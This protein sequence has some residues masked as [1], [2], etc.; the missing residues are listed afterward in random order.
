MEI[1]IELSI[2]LTI[3]V[4]ISVLMRLL[5][6]PLIIG[7]ILAGILVSPYFLNIVQS[8]QT[9][10]V[11]SQIGVTFLLFIVGMSLSPKVIKEVGKVSLITG[12]GQIIFTSLFGF[13]IAILLGF[14]TIVSLYIAIALTFSSTIIIMKLLSDKK[15]LE[16][17]YGKISIGFLLVQDLFVII[18]LMVI[19]SFS[20]NLDIGTFSTWSA[21]IGIILITGFI[22]ISLYILPHL[23]KFFAK[24]QELLF[25]FSIGWGLGLAALFHYLGLSMEIGALVAGIALSIT[26]FH[27][28]ISSKMRSLRDFFIILFFILLGSQMVFGKISE[29]LIPAILFSLFILIGNPLIVLILMGLLGYRKKT[30]FQAG[31]TVAQISEFSLILI[32]LGVSVGHLTDEILSLVTIVGLITISG[33]TYLILYSDKIYPH[34]SK[35]LSIFERKNLKEKEK[36]LKDYE[37]VLFGYNKIGWDILESIKKIGKKYLVVDYDPET[38][39]GLSRKNINYKYGDIG[40]DEFLNEVD[41]SKTK[42]VIST[43]P[44][45]ET[46]LLLINKIKKEKKR[47]LIIIVTSRNL[48]EAKQLYEKGA[49]YVIMP[50]FLGGLYVSEMIDNYQLDLKK[51]LKEKKEHLRYIKN[52]KSQ[53]H[54][55]SGHKKI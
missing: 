43:I 24:S 45:L 31:F 26:P 18:L 23:S 22:L 9:I 14:S 27:Y 28:E 35:F 1:F 49:T 51:F 41:F 30:S 48:E 37:I 53:K 8:T 36:N 15:D 16:K 52:K 55:Y 47:G 13:L 10:K 40:E 25:L 7:Y 6:Q 29:L 34:I 50:D 44:E 54:K 38:I 33:S 11:F 12:I 21:L 4:L 19:S 46:N 17:L 20:E 5:K 2:L 42:M 3:T 32:T 39:I